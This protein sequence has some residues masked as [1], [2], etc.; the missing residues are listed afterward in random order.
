MIMEM[1]KEEVADAIAKAGTRSSLVELDCYTAV[2]QRYRD[3]PVF[4]PQLDSISWGSAP[5]RSKT[6]DWAFN[7]WG[8]CNN[9]SLAKRYGNSEGGT[10]TVDD[11]VA[12]MVVGF[13]VDA[14]EYRFSLENGQG[15]V[16]V[17][18]LEVGLLRDAKERRLHVIL[19]LRVHSCVFVCIDVFDRA[20]AHMM[21]ATG[22]TVSVS[23]KGNHFFISQDVCQISLSKAITGMFGSKTNVESIFSLQS[24]ADATAKWNQMMN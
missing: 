3:G 17:H 16:V 9:F 22:K 20:S 8:G 1:F 10:I 12:S 23:L 19:W 14:S 6:K 7:V 4:G 18:S 2:R 13:V 5:I 24:R 11:R 15:Q 21:M